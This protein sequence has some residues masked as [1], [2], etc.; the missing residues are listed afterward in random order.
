MH[1][2]NKMDVILFSGIHGT[3]CNAAGQYLFRDNAAFFRNSGAE[4]RV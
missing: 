3:L 2:D 1:R 4:D